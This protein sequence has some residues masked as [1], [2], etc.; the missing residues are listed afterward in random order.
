MFRQGADMNGGLEM[1]KKV[2]L[3][4]LLIWVFAAFLL[5]EGMGQ[6]LFSFIGGLLIAPYLTGKVLTYLTREK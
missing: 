3:A 6:R 5:P 2:A 4:G 1:D